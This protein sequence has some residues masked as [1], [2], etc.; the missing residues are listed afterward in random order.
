MNAAAAPDGTTRHCVMQDCIELKLES[1][2]DTAGFIERMP[3]PDEYHGWRLDK[4]RSRTV[5]QQKSLSLC[6]W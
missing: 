1:V 6:W 2:Q 5:L 4:V 3:L